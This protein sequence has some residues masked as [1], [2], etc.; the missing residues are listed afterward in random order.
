MLIYDYARIT[1]D[2]KMEHLITLNKLS[3][4]YGFE[5]D[6]ITLNK[7][8]YQIVWLRKQVHEWI[9]KYNSD[10]FPGGEVAHIHWR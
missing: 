1:K 2:H 9:F 3:S 5:M 8:M 7:E 4:I 10:W 6:Q